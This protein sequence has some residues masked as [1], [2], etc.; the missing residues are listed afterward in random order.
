[1]RPSLMHLSQVIDVNKDLRGN[2]IHIVCNVN[3]D[4]MR[5]HIFSILPE[6]EKYMYYYW[7]T[8]VIEIG[9]ITRCIVLTLNF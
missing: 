5:L 2:S 9:T 1:M 8:R 6:Y 3:E 7:I 4:L